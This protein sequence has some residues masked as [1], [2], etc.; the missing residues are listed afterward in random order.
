M[1]KINDWKIVRSKTGYDNDG[2]P[3]GQ[4]ICRDRE[5]VTEVSKR[6]KDSDLIIE[7]YKD[8]CDE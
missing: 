7:A 2:I 5:I 8:Q 3:V 4:V 6:I 1:N